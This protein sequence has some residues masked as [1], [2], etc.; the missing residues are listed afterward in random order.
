LAEAAEAGNGN[1]RQASSRRTIFAITFWQ[2]R[3]PLTWPATS[4]R[5]S[6]NRTGWSVRFSQSWA[7]WQIMTVT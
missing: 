2:A 7:V 5:A 1:P 6:A 4:A 3:Q